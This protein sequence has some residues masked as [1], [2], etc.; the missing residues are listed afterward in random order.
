MVSHLRTNRHE[1]PHS[2]AFCYS[3]YHPKAPIECTNYRPRVPPEFNGVALIKVT[4]HS[5]D[6]TIEN[7]TMMNPLSRFVQLYGNSDKIKLRN[8]RMTCRNVPLPDVE[9]VPFGIETGSVT[10]VDID[11]ISMEFSTQKNDFS[12]NGKSTGT[13]A[14]FDVGTYNLTMRNVDCKNAWGGALVE[15]GTIDVN[16]MTDTMGDILVSNFT[17]DGVKAT[18]F[19]S[20]WGRGKKFAHNITWD[21]VTV[22]SGTPAEINICYLRLHNSTPYPNECPRRV[23]TEILDVW[24]KNFKGRVGPM[25]TDPNWGNWNDISHVEAHFENWVDVGNGTVT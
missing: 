4:N 9:T 20:Y 2:D 1:T 24:F 23:E 22:K 15:Y 5:S 16:F 7:L 21:G 6:V 11:N 18:G 12:P 10:N 25:P 8:L 14:A 17:F 3:H 13:C 19:Q